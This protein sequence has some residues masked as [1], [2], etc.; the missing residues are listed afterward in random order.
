[1]PT[2]SALG[3]TTVCQGA[4]VTL[5]ASTGTNYLWSNGST[6]QSISVNTSGNYTVTVSDASGC[7]N[8]SMPIT[9]T[10]NPLPALPTI[11]SSGPTT[12]CSGTTVTLTAP[13]G[14]NYLWNTGATT[15]AITVS[16]T[17]NYYV[18]IT[19]TNGCSSISPITTVTVNAVPPVPTI[20]P[21]G[22]INF[23]A[24]ESVTLT[25]PAGYSY[26]WSTGA[27]TQSII[28]S[29][30][31]FYNVRVINASN[32][33]ALSPSILVTVN[34]TPP[35]PILTQVGNTLFSSAPSG[36]QWYLNGTLIPGAT[37]NSYVITSGGVY[38]VTV[39]NTSGCMSAVSGGSFILSEFVQLGNNEKF[40]FKIYPSPFSTQLRIEY[41][42]EQPH[43]VAIQLIDMTGKTIA[44][45]HPSQQNAGK[46][47]EL[48]DHIADRLQ[49]ATYLVQFII[50]D[51]KV[52]RLVI[53]H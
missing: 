46:Y 52:S 40:Y 47:L 16:S 29:S 44:V 26:L 12:F 51:F 23:C 4:S 10:V 17:G 34:P 18:T 30:S 53:K 45:R 22:P 14:F 1:M 3:P 20:I 43:K 9:V 50:D 7:S 33:S 39:T 13:A 37:G 49:R 15:R 36:N 41:H 32:C 31:G 8:T 5:M 6:T 2:I 28:V 19:N 48:L 24:G 35:A 21:D 27:T 25:A 42:L 11:I 38:S